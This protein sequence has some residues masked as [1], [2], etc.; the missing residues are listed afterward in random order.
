[1]GRARQPNRQ[2]SAADDAAFHH[3]VEKAR[4]R[5]YL[6]DVVARYTTLRKRGTRELVGLCP[7]HAEKSPSFEVNDAKGVYY[8]HGCGASGD[9]FRFLMQKDGLTFR[10]AFEALTGDSFPVVSEE[11]RARRKEADA[12]DIAERVALARSIWAASLP[13][14][15]TPAE[16][17]A[18]SRGISAPLPETARFVMTAR[19]RNSE[20][21]EVG[22]DHPAMACA[23]QDAAG[24]IV[25]V[26]CIFLQ[27][28]GRRKYDHVRE[29]GTKA[30]AKLSFGV[31]VGSAFRIGPVS[32]HIVICEG[33]EDGLTLGQQLP[34]QTVWVAC[35]T[36][37]MSKVSIPAGVRKITLAGDNGE[38]GRLAVQQAATAYL[39]LGLMVGSAF[40]DPCFKDWNDELMEVRI[41]DNV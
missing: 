3:A 8:C 7:F 19:W 6:S 28:G 31:I 27:N 16:V 1:M 36:A 12:R 32:D 24:E 35:G 20:T 5:H 13:A 11:E 30:K 41:G 15:G 33:P 22:R 17:Y 9:A 29:D 21:G 39:D 26:Q 25:G 40:P 38:A 23:L 14:A 34:D 10:E 2:R 37:M 4:E 18:R